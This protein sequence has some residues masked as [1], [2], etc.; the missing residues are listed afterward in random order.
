VALHFIDS[1]MTKL[2]GGEG[3]DK[4]AQMG[5]YLVASDLMTAVYFPYY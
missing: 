3:A 4:I 5:F 1:S 2:N